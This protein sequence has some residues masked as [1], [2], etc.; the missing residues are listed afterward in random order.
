MGQSSILK[1]LL[2]RPKMNYQEAGSRR[3]LSIVAGGEVF[4]GL[5]KNI[6][7]SES[8]YN[9]DRT[10]LVCKRV[11]D[12]AISTVAIREDPDPKEIRTP[13]T[14]FVIRVRVPRW[15]VAVVVGGVAL[16]ALL[17]ALDPD[18]V[19]FLAGVLTAERKKAIED[20]ARAIAGIARIFSPL[21][22]AVSAYVAFKRLPIK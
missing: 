3:R 19:R 16:T 14:V 20:N 17:L 4:S 7:Y 1:V 18:T 9:E 10:I 2:A 5:S 15:V 21:P 13:Q 11:F 12:T 6:I 22:V 8:R